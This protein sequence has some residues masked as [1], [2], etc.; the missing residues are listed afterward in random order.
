ME[1]PQF[2]LENSRYFHQLLLQLPLFYF[3]GQYYCFDDIR[4]IPNEPGRLRF[5]DPEE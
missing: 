3:Q 4:D 1:K 5:A 2:D